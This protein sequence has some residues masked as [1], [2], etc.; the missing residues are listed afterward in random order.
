ME[1]PFIVARQC[2]CCPAIAIAICVPTVFGNLFLMLKN[3][4]F[5]MYYFLPSGELWICAKT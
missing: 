5:F 3:Q 4:L 1:D 2:S